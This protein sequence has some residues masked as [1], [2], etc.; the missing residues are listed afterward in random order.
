MSTNYPGV[1]GATQAPSAAAVPGNVPTVVLPD[2]GDDLDAASVA[3]AYK[4]L[5]DFCAMASTY[6]GYQ[7]AARSHWVGSEAAP[8][9]SA[10]WTLNDGPNDYRHYVNSGSGSEFLYFTIPLAYSATSYEKLTSA[11][12]RI[13]K[14]GTTVSTVHVYEYDV[15]AITLSSLGSST[16]S[17]AGERTITVSGLT[18]RATAAKMILVSVSGGD[19]VDKARGVRYVTTETPV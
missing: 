19:A 18:A 12:V 7:F 6:L 13:Y 16:D 4:A 10:T 11:S 3:Q 8:L 1:P 15:D 2:D 9:P 17:T 5:A 14:D